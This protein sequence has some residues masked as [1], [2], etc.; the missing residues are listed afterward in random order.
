[1]RTAQRKSTWLARSCV[2]RKKYHLKNIF[3]QKKPTYF[4]AAG[5]ANC[6]PPHFFA[7]DNGAKCCD[8]D[9][10]ADGT[11]PLQAVRD[12]KEQKL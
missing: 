9:T 11:T 1:M 12:H 4:F 5:V 6:A 10:E 7:F 3:F 8:S 2:V